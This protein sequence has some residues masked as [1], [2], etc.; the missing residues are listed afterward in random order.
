MQREGV[1]STDELGFEFRRQRFVYNEEQ[2][3]FEKLKFPVKVR[4]VPM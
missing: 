4:H 2:N 3:A 1:I